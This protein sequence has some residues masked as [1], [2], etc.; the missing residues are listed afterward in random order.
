MSNSQAALDRDDDP[1]ENVLFRIISAIE[2]H[3]PR[4]AIVHNDQEITYEMLADRSNKIANELE[5]RKLK[6]ETLVPI[7]TSGGSDMI[8]A[9]IGILKAGCAFVPFDID[10]PKRRTASMLK[11]VQPVVSVV[12]CSVDD[13]EEDW[14][15]VFSLSDIKTEPSDH[16]YIG[17]GGSLA[18]G[19][20]T[21]GSTGVPKCCLNVH[22]GLVNRFSVMSDVF[23][24][25]PGEAVL[26][27]SKHTFDSSLWQI[28]W[29]LSVGATVVIPNR[30]GILDVQETLDTIAK[31]NVV[32]ADFVPSILDV[33]LQQFEHHPEQAGLL[34]SMRHILVGGEEVS[35][36]I[37]NGCSRRLPWIKITNT[38]GPT[39]ASIG[40]V[41]HHFEGT[42]SDPLPLGKPIANTQAAVVD[43]NL[44][45]VAPGE[46]G[47]IVIGGRCMGRG[48]LRNPEK[49]A[50]SF[51]NAPHLNLGS[52][53]VFLTGD[54]GRLQNGLLFFHGRA[55]YQVKIRGVRI[56]LGEI[57][58]HLEKID[59][60]DQVR[61]V[62]IDGH[63]GH[64]KLAA[65]L[66]GREELSAEEI[67]SHLKDNLPKEFVP[68]I[69][70]FIDTFP[71]TTS[72]KIDRKELQYLAGQTSAPVGNESD[73]GVSGELF[74][75]LEAYISGTS[76]D[77]GT[78]I[79]EA[80]LDSLNLITLA[81]EIE[82]QFNIRI[83][84]SDIYDF[85]SVGQLSNLITKKM[86]LDE[87][88]RQPAKDIDEFESWRSFSLSRKPRR[89]C[90]LLTGATGY[91]GIHTLKELTKRADL[92]SI[93][94]L[95]RA[96][97]DSAGMARLRSA[98][99]D[100]RIH[101]EIDWSK[102][103]VLNGD[104][105]VPHAGLTWATWR[106]LGERVSEIFHCGAE[107]NFVKRFSD[108]VDTNVRGTSILANFAAEY[109]IDHFHHVSTASVLS[110]KDQAGVAPRGIRWTPPDG[111]SQSKLAAECVVEELSRQNV[112]CTVY[113]L[114]E[115]MPSPS[116]PVPNPKALTTLMLR[117]FA[118]LGVVY[119]EN[120][121]IDY[122]P[123][124]VVSHMVA[125]GT[126]S[127]GP[128]QNNL[129]I[130]D[131]SNPKPMEFANIS[132]AFQLAGVRVERISKAD[133]A[134]K[135]RRKCKSADA[136]AEC[137]IINDLIRDE[138]N[139][140]LLQERRVPDR[141][142]RASDK[143]LA[144]HDEFAWPT[145]DTAFLE[146]VLHYLVDAD[147]QS[148][149]RRL[150]ER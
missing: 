12:D 24:L 57:E 64:A 32:M 77:A 148:G 119:S 90:V 65:F 56:E 16:G 2:T 37:V 136:T 66:I 139:W 132:H 109:E 15:E 51:V 7:F 20:F 84:A 60:I 36:K 9:M 25:K 116:C 120:K 18:Y 38:Y 5:R 127:T 14:G 70:K 22:R 89:H 105:S 128:I 93:I 94:C 92:T 23:D 39:E 114:G 103:E 123:I 35:A 88:F 98:A 29:P 67:R 96:N 126:A 17:R 91:V 61:V 124:D 54:L 111:Y 1:S 55:D 50:A 97:S 140:S 47:Q 78:N 28:L 30:H 19:F 71:R 82:S 4:V 83:S 112:P 149:F 135:V 131:V 113:R 137:L 115:V 44:K 118:Q 11:T 121:S 34:N 13:R 87:D 138:E 3:G 141:H 86:Q 73:N 104:L 41:F 133:F 146:P 144:R 26:Q 59:G 31:W 53:T 10:A 110:E 27:N 99:G 48:Y 72:G 129:G 142:E 75:L 150:G 81:L 101:S 95:V 76:F 145:V 102:I 117:S 42:Q 43:D 74:P 68:A 125:N 85:P 58:S 69:F 79:V 147:S 134:I 63:D 49:T 122:S 100:Q 33:F 107:V 8:A 80:G 62:S 108:L 106:Q 46:V 6:P 45:P 40:M 52:D 143:T 130:I 21:S